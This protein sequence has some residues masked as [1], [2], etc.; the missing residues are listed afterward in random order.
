MAIVS[1]SLLLRSFFIISVTF[2]FLFF[3]RSFTSFND[4]S[5]RD[6]SSPPR[7]H[8]RALPLLASDASEE[9]TD[10]GTQ[11]RKTPPAL[12]QHS[13]SEIPIYDNSPTPSK[14]ITPSPPKQQAKEESFFNS[15][16]PINIR[17]SQYTHQTDIQYDEEKWMVWE[18]LTKRDGVI[19]FQSALTKEQRV[20][21]KTGEA[22]FQPKHPTYPKHA[23]I[24]L[25]QIG[26]SPSDLLANALLQ[27]GEPNEEEVKATIPPLNS[28]GA[29]KRPGGYSPPVWTSFVGTVEAFDNVPVYGQGN[30]RSYQTAQHAPEIDKYNS[31]R[32]EGRVGG[33]MPAVRKVLTEDVQE[34]PPEDFI[35]TIT[36]GEVDAKDPFIVQTWH[37]LIHVTNGTIV[38]T[39]YGHSYPTFPK[40]AK[41]VRQDEFYRSLFRFG[42][43]WS[44]RLN[45]VVQITLPDQSWVDMPKYAFAKELMVRPGGN[46][47]KYGAIDRDYYGSEYDGFQDI[48]TSS[49]SANLEWGRFGQAWNVI[50]NYFLLF[51]GKDGSINMRGPE[52]GQFGM[53]LSLLAK[54]SHYT[55]ETDLLW[56]HKDKIVAIAK[57]LTNLHDESLALPRNSSGYGLLHGWSESDASLNATPDLY[58]QPYF[59]NSAMAARGLRDISTIE[60]VFREHIS[61]WKNRAAQ[62]TNRTIDAITTSIHRT[63]TPQ[64]VPVLP[65]SNLT[66]RESMAKEKPSPQAWSHRLYTEL[67]HSAIL[68]PSLTNL[69]INTMRS[70][71]ATSAGVVANVVPPSKA[72]RDILGFISYGYAYSL[73]LSDRIDEFILFLYT[74]RYHVHTRG[75]WNAGEVVDIVGGNSLFCIPA[76]LTIPSILRW[77]LVLEHPDE[78]ILYLGR[79]IP[80]AWLASG[81]EIGINQAPTRWGRVDFVV[82]YENGSTTA[83]ADG[84]G[85]S[86]SSSSS[87]RIRAQVRFAKEAP[88]PKE[89]HVK[90]RL[91]GGRNLTSV[92]VNGRE[93]ELKGEDAVVRLWFTESPLLVEG[94]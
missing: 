17:T 51:V 79:G 41:E 46:Y 73:L 74:H 9:W 1:H 21:S 62:L 42:E 83:A 63:K 8:H 92:R 4:P 94:F 5:S 28:R 25:S 31:K 6:R 24:P 87:P 33:W 56:K 72:G 84:G 55:G 2:N 61:N 3:I 71:G 18:D 76:Q 60:P 59:S 35:E 34:D 66:F 58:W 40:G 48:F 44:T 19:V 54:Y 80:R 82:K 67:L 37:R 36:F 16:Q 38:K 49:V 11:L 14:P 93:A 12:E 26:L 57:V 22:S 89:V 30:T 50:D 75:A 86:S 81:R 70:Y 47:P 77:A 88:V 45:D 32:F 53:T 85:G 91:P 52:I 15:P 23:S 39:V 64:Y 43:Y 78:E 90:F 27:K 13:S 20:F 65:G 10:D 68:P 7:F 69:V 29:P